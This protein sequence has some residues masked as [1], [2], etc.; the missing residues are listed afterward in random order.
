M[1]F[2]RGNNNNLNITQTKKINIFN[3]CFMGV[4]VDEHRHCTHIT[5]LTFKHY[6]LW[7]FFSV[8]NRY[9][10]NPVLTQ[11]IIMLLKQCDVSEPIN[12]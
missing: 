7:V 1:H 8:S 9:H 4:H 5:L 11:I 6:V 3:D 2:H 12:R 10:A